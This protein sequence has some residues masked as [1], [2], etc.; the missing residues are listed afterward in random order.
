MHRA[1]AVFDHT[2]GQFEVNIE[3]VS[4][5]SAYIANGG[6]CAE[7]LDY[8]SVWY[9]LVYNYDTSSWETLWTQASDDSDQWGW[10]VW[11]EWNFNEQSWPDLSSYPIEAKD[12]QIYYYGYVTSSYGNEQKD[13]GTA[14]YACTWDNQY[15]RWH[16]TDN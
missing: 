4:T 3:D 8:N 11:E 14:P 16:V 7:I 1:I 9:A 13:M 6:Y 12:I 5:I 2:T 10:C 15:Y